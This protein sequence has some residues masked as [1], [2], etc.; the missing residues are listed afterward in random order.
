MDDQINKSKELFSG[1]EL[2]NFDEDDE[3]DDDTDSE[4]EWEFNELI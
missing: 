1:A 4:L 3:D 2:T